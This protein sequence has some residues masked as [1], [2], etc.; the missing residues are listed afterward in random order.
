MITQHFDAGEVFRR[1]LERVLKTAEE[2]VLGYRTENSGL[3]D[4][5]NAG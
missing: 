1:A 5:P 4:W 3:R 2:T